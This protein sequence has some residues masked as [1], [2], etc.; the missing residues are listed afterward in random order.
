M[1]PTAVII[2]GDAEKT[3]GQKEVKGSK[4]Q[5]YTPP[6]SSENIMLLPTWMTKVATYQF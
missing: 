3:K 1:W 2:L 4:E 6:D 5:A